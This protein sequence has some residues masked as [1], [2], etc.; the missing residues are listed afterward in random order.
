MKT[1]YQK[2]E[3]TESGKN[4]FESFFNTFESKLYD[5]SICNNT[6]VCETLYQL[7]MGKSSYKEDL[8]GA[9]KSG[10]MALL[11]KLLS[12]D[13]NQSAQEPEYYSD[14]DR[15]KYQ[16][17]K[18]IHWLWTYFDK[19][20]MSRNTLFAFRFRRIMGKFMFKHL[21]DNVKIFHNVEFSYGYNLSIDDNVVIHREV[22]LDDRAGI[23]IKKNASVSDFVNIYSH[24]HDTND[25]MDISLAATVIGE[26]ARVTYHSTVLAGLSLGDHAVLGAMSLATKSLKPLEVKGGIPAKKITMVQKDHHG[27]DCFKVQ[28]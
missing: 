17:N 25:I 19:L 28:D 6:L 23:V 10:D 18:P 2:L 14:I 3:P 9:E 12:Y 5:E 15:V 8:L 13:A 24:N 1:E 22:M 7:D 21:G 4:L 26:G 11:L 16:R 27:H 20:P